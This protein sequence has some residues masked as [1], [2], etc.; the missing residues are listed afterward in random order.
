MYA[1]R[2]ALSAIKIEL[3]SH[4]Q[5]IEVNHQ[6]RIFLLLS[7]HALKEILSA[8]FSFFFTAG[9]NKANAVFRRNILQA[10]GQLK[11]DAQPR[12]IV[13]QSL[14]RQPAEVIIDIGVAHRRVGIKV[15]HNNN[16][17]SRLSFVRRNDRAA[18]Y[19]MPVLRFIA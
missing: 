7:G 11:H 3:I 19:V 8:E 13:I 1:A 18:G 2:R 15:R 12:R 5:I 16:L 6:Q 9:R 14:K 17:L 10:F 4:D